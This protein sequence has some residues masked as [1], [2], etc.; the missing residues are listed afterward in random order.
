MLTRI[1][2]S[3][4]IISNDKTKKKV[5]KINIKWMREQKGMTQVHLAQYLGIGQS[6]VAMWESGESMP[7]ADKLPEL[8]RVL[9]CSIDDLF[10]D[11]PEE[12][13]A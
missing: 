12:T 5:M 8:A 4:N 11:L 10:R 7:R 3:V 13:S 1:I 9:G 6:T 2:Q